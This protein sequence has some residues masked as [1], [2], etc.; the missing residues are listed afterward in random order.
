MTIYLIA[1]L[2]SFTTVFLKGFQHKNV[3]HNLYGHTF[4]T[5]YFMA[6]TDVLMVG[7]IAKSIVEKDDWTIALFS[8]TGAAFGMVAAMYVHNR[9]VK[10]EG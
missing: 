3:L 5:S 10:K 8:G 9:F 6:A 7:L 2:A 1:V 4:V